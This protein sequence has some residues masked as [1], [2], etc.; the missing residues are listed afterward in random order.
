MCLWEEF[1]CL[2]R[3]LDEDYERL[4]RH[5]NALSVRLDKNEVEVQTVVRGAEEVGNTQRANEEISLLKHEVLSLTSQ[6]KQLMSSFWA[7]RE[8]QVDV[9]SHFIVDHTSAMLVGT[10]W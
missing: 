9:S 10:L 5:L 2:N 1:E 4:S 7:A 3:C 8:A 6:L